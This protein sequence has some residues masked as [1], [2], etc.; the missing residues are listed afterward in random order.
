MKK[1]KRKTPQSLRARATEIKALANA[2]VQDFTYL[3]S[4][5]ELVVLYSLISYMDTFLLK[6]LDSNDKLI[7]Y[8]WIMMR[9]IEVE[10]ILSTSKSS[11]IKDIVKKIKLLTTALETE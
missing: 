4:T 1:I 6:C 8:K 2:L 10:M 3:V 11:D 7:N 9:L 5:T